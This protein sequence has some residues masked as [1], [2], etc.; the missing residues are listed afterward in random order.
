MVRLEFNGVYDDVIKINEFSRKGQKMLEVLFHSR[1]SGKFE[2]VLSNSNSFDI[3]PLHGNILFTN[4]SITSDGAAMQ[5]IVSDGSDKD[6]R[7]VES[8]P[9]GIYIKLYNGGNTEI[10]I[11]EWELRQITDVQVVHKFKSGTKIGPKVYIVVWPNGTS[12][13]QFDPPPITNIVMDKL[14]HSGKY[15][16]YFLL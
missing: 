1:V 3:V 5:R 8:G 11:G 13:D 12:A 4:Y 16:E 2:N 14:W 15:F 9:D 7:I 10:D 6:V